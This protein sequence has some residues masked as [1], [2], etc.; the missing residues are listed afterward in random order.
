LAVG[1]SADWIH[2]VSGADG[3]HLA[4]F[5][6]INSSIPVWGTLGI[7]ADASV[8]LRNSYF[9]KFPDSRTR[10][11]QLRFYLTWWLR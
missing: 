6:F 4:Q 8:S 5:A 10:N 1:Y 3:S 2:T 11:P 9:I 7:G